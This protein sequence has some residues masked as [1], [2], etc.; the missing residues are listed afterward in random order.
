MRGG[1]VS[2]GELLGKGSTC[3]L[4]CQVRPDRPHQRDDAQGRDQVFVLQSAED[5]KVPAVHQDH[6]GRGETVTASGGVQLTE[7]E[8]WTD[9]VKTKRAFDT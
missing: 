3:V 9:A 1:P 8:S 5:R 4:F 6:R 7:G 2:T